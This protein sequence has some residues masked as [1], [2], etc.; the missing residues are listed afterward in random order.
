MFLGSDGWTMPNRR[1]F[2]S[3]QN[4]RGRDREIRPTALSGSGDP[5]YSSYASSEG[6]NKW[7]NRADNLQHTIVQR[8]VRRHNGAIRCHPS[9]FQE[10]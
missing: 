8:S 1:L 2:S 7:L 4:W 3:I 5:S 10:I 9:A 6:L